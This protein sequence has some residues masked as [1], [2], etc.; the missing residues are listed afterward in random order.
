MGCTWCVRETKERVERTKKKQR[1]DARKVE[2]KQE[3]VVG[4]KKPKTKLCRV[5]CGVERERKREKQLEGRSQKPTLGLLGFFCCS[6][7]LANEMSGFSAPAHQRADDAIAR[8]A[9]IMH[10]AAAIKPPRGQPW[11]LLLLLLAVLGA[12]RP[13][14][15]CCAC[16]AGWLR[17]FRT[18][19][20]ARSPAWM[21]PLM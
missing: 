12:G 21:P 13:A 19:C 20:T 11:L 6:F 16:A 17:L 1:E 2:Q 7:L 14:G 8:H 5:L 15:S 10:A 3:A 9:K 4:Q 18:S